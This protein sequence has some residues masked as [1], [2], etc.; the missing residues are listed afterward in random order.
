[1]ELYTSRYQNPAIPTCGYAPV[2]VTLGFPRFIRYKLV[3]NRRELAPDRSIFGIED[4]EIFTQL[5]RERLDRLG[6]RAMDILE[7]VYAKAGRERYRG[8]VLLCYEDLR[9]PDMWCHRQIVAQWLQERYG[10]VVPELAEPPTPDKIARSPKARTTTGGRGL[11]R[12]RRPTKPTR[13]PSQQRLP[14]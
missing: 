12:P 1:M 14:F 6:D 4:Q 2:G 10:I 13:A 5:M 3:A 11:T 8:L 9:K 7:S